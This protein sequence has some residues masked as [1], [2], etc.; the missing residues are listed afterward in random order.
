MMRRRLY[1]VIIVFLLLLAGEYAAGT[2][3]FAAGVMIN[4]DY[5]APAGEFSRLSGVQGSPYPIVSYDREKVSLFREYHVELCRFPQDCYP[6][7]LTLAGIFPVDITNPDD[8]GNYDFSEIDRHIKAAREAG[9]DIL[10]QS[11]YDVGHS[12]F[13]VTPNLGGRAPENMM[14]WCRVVEK[15]LEHFN[16]GWAGGSDYAVKYVEFVNE[17]NGLGGFKGKESERLIPAFIEFIGT[18][19]RYNRNHPRTPVKAVGPGIPFSW[20]QWGTW[21][22]R[23]RKLFTILKEQKVTLPV[24][25]FHTYGRDTSPQAN[26]KIARAYRALLDEYGMKGTALWNS[27]WQAGGFLKEYLNDRVMAAQS[28]PTPEEVAAYSKAIATYALSCKIRWQGIL[29]GS[30][31]YLASARAF[32]PTIEE[33]A[34]KRNFYAYCYFTPEN[35]AT[36]LACHERLTWLVKE[37]TPLRCRTVVLQDDGLFAGLGT[38]SQAGDRA[39]LLIANLG[40]EKRVVTV[41]AFLPDEW[42]DADLSLATLEGEKPFP[43]SLERPRNKGDAWKIVLGVPPLDSWFLTMIKRP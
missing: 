33:K 28:S 22:P 20:D 35:K 12:D 17:P 21:E 23:F 41:N 40:R 27:E 39:G 13:W 8:P 29:D 43:G 10:W 19:E 14:R 18:I 31:Y 38:R 9:C 25:S 24:L 15:C 30:C 37:K 42:K 2:P 6:N 5:R 4:V 32:P 36:P 16:N 34:K 11:S 26:Q 7:T 3:V 1:G